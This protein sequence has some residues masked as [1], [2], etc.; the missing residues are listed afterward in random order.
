M[1][2]IWGKGSIAGHGYQPSSSSEVLKYNFYPVLELH[3]STP[4]GIIHYS[5]RKE[6]DIGVLLIVA[7]M[8]DGR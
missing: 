5:Q 4:L 7:R 6:Q 8:Q 2:S 1:S 3:L